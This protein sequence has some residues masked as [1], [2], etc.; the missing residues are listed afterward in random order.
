ML[1]YK[2][3]QA[4]NQSYNALMEAAA[5]VFLFTLVSR[6]VGVHN[7]SRLFQQVGVMDVS[8]VGASHLRY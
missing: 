2:Y 4:F 5:S 7:L 6:R 3:Q 8:A 1:L